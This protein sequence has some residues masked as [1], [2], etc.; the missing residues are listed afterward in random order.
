M[1]FLDRIRA[2]ND[3]DLSHFRPW[4][5]AGQTVGFIHDDFIATL[6][7]W[8]DVFVIDAQSVS[9]NAELSKAGISLQQRS[10]VVHEIVW[11][12]H[13]EQQVLHWRDEPY[14]VNRAFHEPPSL[15]LER[16]AIELFGVAGYGVHMNGYVRNEQGLQLWV[17]RRAYNKPTGPG[18]LDQMVAG[19][20][21]AGISLDDNLIKECAEEAAIP[22]TLA[23]Q[24]VATGA[25]SYCLQTAQGLR[26]DVLYTYDLELPADFVPHNTDGEVDAFYL[27]PVQQVLEIIRDSDEFKFN[28]ALVVIDFMIRHGVIPPEHPDYL[29]LLS[30]LRQREI[31]LSSLFLS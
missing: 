31:V 24:A 26:P 4:V 12:L 13:L 3:C 27:W 11:Q 2:A 8:S 28:C 21:P 14:A 10:A 29:T 18:K 19:G 1:S 23:Q 17:A 22:H 9:L 25:V 5:I 16:A 30:G 6:Q 20:Q 15:L 7:R